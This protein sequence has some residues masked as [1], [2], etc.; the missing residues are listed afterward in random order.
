[1]HHPPNLVET[2]QQ[3][4]FLKGEGLKATVGNYVL[5]RFSTAPFPDVLFGP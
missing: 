4:P 1:M 5:R 2:E 3:E